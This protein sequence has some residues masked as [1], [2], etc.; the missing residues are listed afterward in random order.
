MG[1]SAKPCSVCRKEVAPSTVETMTGEEAG[2]RMSIDGMPVLRCAEGHRRFVTPDFAI[3]LMQALTADGPLA[4]IPAAAQKG[5]FRKRPHCPA[6]GKEL[7]EP[8]AE[9]AQ[10]SRTLELGGGSAISV[11]I[12]MPKYR[13]AACAKE[14]V[15]PDAILD[16]ALMKASVHAFRSVAL[17]PT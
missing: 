9:R 16:D 7:G 12:E 4:P 5:L 15:P 11:R 3:R 13:C 8:A 10:V 2:V 6:C 17:R 1:P 14:C